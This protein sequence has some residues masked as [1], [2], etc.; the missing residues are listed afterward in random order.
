MSKRVP[1][2]HILAAVF[3]T[4]C[5]DCGELIRVGDLIM[6]RKYEW[7]HM[8]CTRDDAPPLLSVGKEV[9]KWSGDPVAVARIDLDTALFTV[10]ITTWRRA[11]QQI[12]ALIVDLFTPITEA[13]NH[14]PSTRQ[15][16]TDNQGRRRGIEAQR[17]PYGPK[18][19]RTGTRGT[20]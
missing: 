17:S 4:V 18:I 10:A 7:I 9:M 14:L 19:Q 15:I 3:E 5:P 13:I 16:M 6:R 20:R 11:L 2:G 12:G 1:E 8:D